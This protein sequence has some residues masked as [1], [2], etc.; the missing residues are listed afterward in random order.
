MPLIRK[1]PNQPTTPSS[2]DLDAA[3]VALRAGSTQERWAAARS[4][5]TLHGAAPALGQALGNEPDHRVREAI[6]TSLVRI[7]STDCVDAVLPYLRCDDANLRNGALDALKAMA[8]VVQA[9]LESLLHDTDPDV[10]V[11]ACDLA[12]EA[13]SVEATRLLSDILD[14]DSAVNVCIA[15]VE[16][17]AEI[18]STDALP[19][20]A[21]C[22]ERFP[23]QPFLGFAARAAGERIGSQSPPRHE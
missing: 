9:R 4:L 5:A 15:A 6:F 16:A 11:L 19:S 20:L 3:V 2:P 17:L 10:R 18:G 7:N 22:V 13:P 21:R 23:D 8:G 14:A 12:R 1:G